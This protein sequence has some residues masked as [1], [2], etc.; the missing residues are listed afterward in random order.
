MTLQKHLQAGRDK[1]RRATFEL[2]QERV[3][4]LPLS[5][6]HSQFKA[7]GC[8]PLFFFFSQR[9]SSERFGRLSSL[10]SNGS[11]QMIRLAFMAFHLIV[12]RQRPL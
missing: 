11:D 10:K 7:C 2:W 12:L 4:G 9:C 3:A 5:L 8:L 6:N 1:Q